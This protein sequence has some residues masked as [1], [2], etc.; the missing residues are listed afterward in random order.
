MSKII[1]IIDRHDKETGPYGRH[2]SDSSHNIT[3]MMKEYAEWYAKECLKIAT[4][5]AVTSIPSHPH[6]HGIKAVDE[7]SILNITLPEHE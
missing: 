1:E 4:Q 3:Q 2:L 5:N 7:A 6:L